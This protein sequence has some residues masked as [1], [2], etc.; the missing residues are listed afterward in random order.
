MLPLMIVPA[1][2]VDV[3]VVAARTANVEADPKPIGPVATAAIP[4]RVA[5]AGM[6]AMVPLQL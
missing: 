6:V 4:L 5:V 3:I 2:A 1:A